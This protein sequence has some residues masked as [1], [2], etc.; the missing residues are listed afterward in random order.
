V[1]ALGNKAIKSGIFY[2]DSGSIQK[3]A[4]KFHAKKVF[5]KDFFIQNAKDFG[6]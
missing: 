6:L 5:M 2:T 4:R 1:P 3:V